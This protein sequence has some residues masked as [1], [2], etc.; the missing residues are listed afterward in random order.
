MTSEDFIAKVIL[1]AEQD[2]RKYCGIAYKLIP[3]RQKTRTDDER[4]EIA[5][6][7]CAAECGITTEAI[8]STSR[9]DKIVNCRKHLAFY[10]YNHLKLS[11]KQIGKIMGNRDHTTILN[12]LNKFDQHIEYEAEFK[13]QWDTIFNLIKQLTDENKNTE[14]S[15]TSAIPGRANA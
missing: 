9:K 7:V 10:L 14:A 15:C 6:Q 11:L 2:I 13:E 1:Q 4:I 3:L 5:I 12:L 8:A